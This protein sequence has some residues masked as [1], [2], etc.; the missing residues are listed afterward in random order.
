M[1]VNVSCRLVF[2][3]DGPRSIR[4]G[5]LVQPIYDWLIV[6][7]LSF[8]FKI[9]GGS[10]R[11][12]RGRTKTVAVISAESRRRSCCSAKNATLGVWIGESG[13]FKTSRITRYSRRQEK[14]PVHDLQ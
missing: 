2:L 9:T 4:K 8:D 10:R 12:R 6:R 14:N 7:S 1:S 5:L 3:S 13:H 11:G